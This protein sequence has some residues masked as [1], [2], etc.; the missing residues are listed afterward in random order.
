MA[1]IFE[2]TSRR[3]TERA[4]RRQTPPSFQAQII[5]FYKEHHIS[6]PGPCELFVGAPAIHHSQVSLHGTFPGSDLLQLN[7]ASEQLML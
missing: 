4:H 2:S 7:P 1:F 3:G 6:Q 5:L